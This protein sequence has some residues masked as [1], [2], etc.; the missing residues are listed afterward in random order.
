M[1]FSKIILPKIVITD[2]YQHSLV[3]TESEITQTKPKKEVKEA[4][5]NNEI[6]SVFQHSQHSVAETFNPE[7]HNPAG[8]AASTGA[9]N[10]IPDKKKK[11]YLGDNKKNVTVVVKDKDA[12]YLKDEPL[13]LFSKLLPALKL[14]LE[15]VAIVNIAHFPVD[16]KKIKYELNATIV[17]MFGVNAGEIDLP[18]TI[19]DYKEQQF[20][21]CRYIQMPALDKLLGDSV[22]VRTEK[23][24]VWVELKKLFGL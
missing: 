15:D 24:K 18:F 13:Q 20:N 3:L 14:N 11:W 7:V 12:L 17:M 8:N 1:S 19:P 5:E 9:G 6:I 4:E 22:A 21:L 16:A 23:S 10:I 2:F